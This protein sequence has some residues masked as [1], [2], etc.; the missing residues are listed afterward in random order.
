MAVSSQESSQE[1]PTDSYPLLME[2]PENHENHEHIV[3]IERG[4]DSS[5]SGSDHN[6]SP[7]GLSLSHHD[8]RPFSSAQV[9]TTQSPSSLSDGS[10]SRGS[11]PM[12]R[13]EGFGRRHWSP[14]NTVFWLSIELV[15]TVG[16]IIAA[17]IVL[18]VSGHENPQTPLFAWVVG[19]AAG[20]AASLP[21]LYWRFLHRIQGTGQGSNQLRRGSSQGNSASEP[22]SYITI[23]L[24]R[25]SEEEDGQ[26][27]STGTWNGP[28]MG[29]PN[30]RLSLLMDHFKMALDCFFAVWFVVGNVWIFGGHSSS[31]DAPNLYRL[32][33]V[34][35]T[36]SCIG[37]AMPFILCAMICCCLPCIISILGVRDDMNRM[38]GAS[39]EIINA[40]PTHKFKLTKNGSSSSRDSTTGVDE[41][42]FVAAGTE[43]E[44][45]ISGEDAV[46][47]ICLAKYADND[48]L[49]ELPCSHFF[50]T[51]C[52]DKW[53]K[54]NASCPLCKFEIGNSNANSPSAA[55]SSQQV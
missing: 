36:F 33:I 27:T 13:G 2:Q 1:S 20:C 49:R 22:N 34:F 6:D 14:F 45:A 16:Q 43:R 18:S 25:S 53:L 24:T 23:S 4:C 3:D 47:C 32:C 10:N 54:I 31:S 21:T 38:R 28:T 29:V 46:C 39:E 7:R 15:F 40:L 52:V 51:E 17:I 37:Y 30:D 35:L 8:D 12:R 41:G 50:H 5:S 19:Y 9:H 55:D 11:S 26:N 48:E 42:G 44:R